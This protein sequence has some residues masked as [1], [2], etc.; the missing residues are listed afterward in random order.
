MSTITKREWINEKTGKKGVAWTLAYTDNRGK[1]RKP[2][3]TSKREAE[4][5]RTEIEHKLSNGTHRTEAAQKT[6]FDASEVYLSRMSKRMNKGIITR[7]YVDN[8]ESYIRNYICTTSGRSVSFDAGIANIKLRQCTPKLIQEFIDDMEEACVSTNTQRNVLSTLGR[9]LKCA[10]GQDW[11]AVKP[12]SELGIE[13]TRED[14]LTAVTPPSKYAFQLL[15]R[16]ADPTLELAIS[17]SGS[18]GVRA[19]EQHALIWKNVD[20]VQGTVSICQARD[21]FG[22]IATTKSKAGVRTIPL[23]Q[24]MTQK[25][26]KHRAETKFSSDDDP[27]FANRLGGFM[28]HHNFIARRFKPLQKKIAEFE[29][30]H[31][32]EYTPTS[33]HANRHFA[34]SSWIE[35][36]L[37]PK[38]VQTFAG[39][40]SLQ[41]TMDLYGHLFPSELHKRAMDQMADDL[42]AFGA[43]MEHT[44]I[45]S[46]E[47]ASKPAENHG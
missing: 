42:F 5:A 21:R 33:W 38:T 23:S 9:V 19:S 36:G 14:E 12:T 1:R 31:G 29:M 41:M 45:L 13:R 3:F 39:H 4:A 18:T 44:E 43:K 16:F 30:S 34:I 37:H 32:R 2:Q 22:K 27:V 47:F 25:L 8:E 7:H 15:L 26:R 28:N 40:A 46:D 24:R 10:V 11:I 20:L 17:F 6:V 35:A